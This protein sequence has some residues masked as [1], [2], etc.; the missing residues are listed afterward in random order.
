MLALYAAPGYSGSGTEGIRA[1]VILD[2]DD[3]RDDPAG[4]S[5]AVQLEG[6]GFE[7]EGAVVIRVHRHLDLVRNRGRDR[8]DGMRH[9]SHDRSMVVPTDDPIDLPVPRDDCREFRRVAQVD[10]VQVGN[11]T[12]KGRVMHTDEGGLVGGCR[13]SVTEEFELLGA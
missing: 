11:A 7:N 12:G 2:V 8:G 9:P 10:R 13:Q 4:R 5:P 6:G 1:R 3:V